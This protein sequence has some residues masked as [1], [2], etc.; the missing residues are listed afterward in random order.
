MSR[1]GYLVGYRAQIT[2]GREQI[3]NSTPINIT[4]IERMIIYTTLMTNKS[5]N[6]SGRVRALDTRTTIIKKETP[7]LLVI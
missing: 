4:V 7:L 5:T 3:E 2:S 6:A 1:K